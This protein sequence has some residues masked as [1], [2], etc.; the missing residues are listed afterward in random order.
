M[1]LIIGNLCSL[2]VTTLLFLIKN[3][4]SKQEISLESEEAPL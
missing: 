4:R 3:L 1:D 2:F